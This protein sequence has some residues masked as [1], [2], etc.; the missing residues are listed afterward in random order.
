MTTTVKTA[1]VKEAEI[2]TAEPEPI[3]DVKPGLKD[4][5]VNSRPVGW[6]RQHAKGVAAGAA[7]AVAVGAAAVLVGRQVA[8]G[9]MDVPFDVDGVAD[10]I[11]TIGG[12]A[13]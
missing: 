13:D 6:V 1:E 10:A 11:P 4:R 7:A 9:A 12:D 2:K 8:D 5:I 3:V